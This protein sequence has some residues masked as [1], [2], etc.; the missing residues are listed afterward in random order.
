MTKFLYAAYCA[1]WVIHI[2]YVITLG[3]RASKLRQDW[4]E[5]RR[6]K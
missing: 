4:D 3:R 1:T 2:V 5:F 6:G